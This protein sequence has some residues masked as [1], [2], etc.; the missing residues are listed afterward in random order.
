MGRNVLDIKPTLGH[1]EL[2][3]YAHCTKHQNDFI[4]SGAMTV[5]VVNNCTT[6][7]TLLLKFGTVL[8][9]STEV[10]SYILTGEDAT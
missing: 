7:H 9:K 10:Q 1:P 5:L 4:R 2:S 6:N 3:V 8:L